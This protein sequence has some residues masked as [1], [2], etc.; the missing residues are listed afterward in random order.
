MLQI[1]KKITKNLFQNHK[2]T[3]QQ[4]GIMQF[5]QS[6]PV[7]LSFGTSLLSKK[8]KKIIILAANN[9]GFEEGKVG[10]C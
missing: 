10:P 9:D 6:P 3:I 5:L 8:Q 4:N 1:E 7:W 2:L